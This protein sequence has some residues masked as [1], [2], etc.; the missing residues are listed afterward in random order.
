MGILLQRPLCRHRA[1]REPLR[2]DTPSP[3]QA[4]R[5]QPKKPRRPGNR[6][7]Y[8]RG[9]YP[10]RRILV[11]LSSSRSPDRFLSSLLFFIFR[12]NG[13]HLSLCDDFVLSYRTA[14]RKSSPIATTT[15]AISM[16]FRTCPVLSPCMVARRAPAAN[17]TTSAAIPPHNHRLA[18][19][20]SFRVLS[21]FTRES[22][23]MLVI[24]GSRL[25]RVCAWLINDCRDNAESQQRR[26]Y[27]AQL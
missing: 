22:A 11:L 25:E 5:P 4:A 21:R 17:I 24:L 26:T 7:M 1:H 2:I 27:L 20:L 14:H 18:R 16:P 8:P 23:S 10:Y 9:R 3:C 15:A 13:R 6:R 12:S 19:R